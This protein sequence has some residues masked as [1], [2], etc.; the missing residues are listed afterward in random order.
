M[1]ILKRGRKQ[2]E[3]WYGKCGDCETIV[4]FER[5]D[6]SNRGFSVCPV[7]GH[8]VA[9]IHEG[10]TDRLAALGIDVQELTG[11]IIVLIVT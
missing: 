6:L 10:Q 2:P 7:C 4:R 3:N 5:K 11:I 8:E 1:E 9:P